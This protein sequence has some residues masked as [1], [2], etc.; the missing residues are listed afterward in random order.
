VQDSR[1]GG[2]TYKYALIAALADLSVELGDDTGRALPLSQ[3]RS[4]RSS[5][6]T[7]RG[8][9]SAPN[10]GKSHFAP[11]LTASFAIRG[12]NRIARK[13]S[14]V[15]PSFVPSHGR[16]FKG[17]FACC[18]VVRMKDHQIGATGL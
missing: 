14:N 7:I 18:S 5:L 10:L 15:R 9:R 11:A 12:N 1:G 2:A 16:D 6:N 8:T 4:Q 3:S 13:R 17:R